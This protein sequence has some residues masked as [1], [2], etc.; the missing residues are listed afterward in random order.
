MNKILYLF[1]PLSAFCLSVGFAQ[2]AKPT[3]DDYYRMIKIPIPEGIVL[4]AG[5]L[6]VMP[7]GKLAVSTRRG[8]IYMVQNAFED[9]AENVKFS[10]WAEG[11]HEVLGLAYADGFLYA[12]QRPEVT[13]IK[14]LD[15]DGRA[16]LFE[17]VSDGWE[18]NG[19]YHEYAF[20]SRFDKEGNMWVVLC[21]T[22]SFS[23]QVPYRGWC[24]RVT[25]DGKMIPTASGIR[26]P[27]GIGLNCKGEVFYCDNQGP[28]N[29]TS[30][31][32]HLTPGSF[33]GHPGGF[34]WYELE[35]TKK[36]LG[37]KL[38]TPVN[39]SRFHKEMSRLPNYRPPAILLPHGKVGN[40]A[41]GIACDSSGGK[42]GPFAGQLFVADQTH[43][44]VNRCF[45]EKINGYYQGACFTFRKG[46]GSGNV[47][48]IQ[49]PDG[50]FY[51]GGTD[52][53]WG[54][55]GGKRFALDRV[56]WTGKTPF[57]ILEMRIKPDGFELEFTKP[58]DPKTATDLAS[59]SLK[60]YTYVFQ[61]KYGSPEVDHTNPV[62]K[63]ATL[64]K[65]GKTVKLVVDGLQVGHV[66]ELKSAGL[67]AKESGHP[68][69]HDLAY[70]TLWHIP[71]G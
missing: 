60:T 37:P 31:L 18:I 10:L 69:L 54:A 13:R 11:L 58:V 36:A 27:G 16:D 26:S 57:E 49:C 8:D 17:T 68:L 70:Y 24:V 15:K 33:Q 45:L 29:G 12:T 39:G 65:D 35:A 47:P 38:D 1:V 3:E 40:S 53:G 52:R 34:R 6:E 56:V 44:V 63:S 25:K 41:S 20:G 67:K 21:L 23:S 4:E 64:A 19:D 51:S 50:S 46:F 2:D 43:S 7:D 30:A 22:G 28:W 48:L 66:H 55:R 59:Y 5:G 14:D 61:A 71:K 9:T 32:K 62:I 42:F